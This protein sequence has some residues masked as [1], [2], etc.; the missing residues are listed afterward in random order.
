[1]SKGVYAGQQFGFFTLIETVKIIRN[2]RPYSGYRCKCIC[3]KEVERM[4]SSLV[5]GNVKSCGCQQHRRWK[6][7]RA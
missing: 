1:M 2:M 7:K 3:G 6:G 5:S 4:T